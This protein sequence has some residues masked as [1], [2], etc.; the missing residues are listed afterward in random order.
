MTVTAE[1]QDTYDYIVVGSGAGGG[2]LSANLARA[3]YRVLLL[4]AGSDYESLKYTVPAFNGL[5]TEDPNMRWD[6]FVKHYS[7]PEQQSRDSKYDAARGGVLYPRA[8]TLGGCT[9]HNALI[10]AVPPDSD[11]D[12]IADVTGDA[13][14]GADQMRRY[15]ERLERCAYV[16]RPGAT[17]DGQTDSRGHGFEGWLG[18]SLANPCLVLG[19]A[20]LVSIAVAAAV[21]SF[22]YGLQRLDEAAR[23]VLT[24][25]FKA[26]ATGANVLGSLVRYVDPNDR[27][28][29]RSSPEGLV[30]VPLATRNGKRNG[31]R[32]YIRETQR[33]IP[34]RLI[35][36]TNCLATRVV[37][38]E[39]NRATG[40]EYLAREHLYAAD[41]LAR[42]VIDAEPLRRVAHARR[43]VILAAGAFNTPQLLMLSGIG[44][45]EE[46]R[47]FGIEARVDRPG[48]G[49]NLQDRYEIGV[50]AEMRTGFE[51]L[52]GLTFRPPN[53]GEKPDPAF[54]QWLRGEGIYTTNGVILGVVK[55]SSPELADPDLFIFGLPARFSGYFPGYSLI[56][57]SKPNHFTWAILKAHTRNLGGTVMLRSADATDVPEINFHYFGEGTDLEGADLRAVVDGVKFARAITDAVPAMCGAEILPGLSTDTDEQL[58]TFVQDEAWGHHA[59]CTCKM[60]RADDP[61]AVVDSEF[62][63]LGTRNLRVVD[64]SIFPRI[65]GFFIVAAVYMVSEKASDVIIRAA[66]ESAPA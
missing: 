19:D 25:V 20:M 1:E 50:V 38:D 35:V 21:Q 53:P 54:S 31:P 26:A 59:S 57:E 47:R 33:L 9:A 45:A 23:W 41:P 7:D 18:T 10:T 66:R 49:R 2:P 13:S 5:A 24:A 4:E 43:E 51:L 32:E 34:D 17:D 42:P 55:R 62:R 56:L 28:A 48:V 52:R 61:T 63:V 46:L 40:I 44:P 12:A 58:R 22:R 36:R 64:A 11:W 60:G 30:L 27:E 39:R 8:G 3:G 6:F 65:P 14:W 16:P 15:F 37:L 29:G